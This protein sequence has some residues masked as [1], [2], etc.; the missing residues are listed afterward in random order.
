MLINANEYYL[1]L[2]TKENNIL[3]IRNFNITNWL[4][5]ILLGVI[6]DYK[7]KLNTRIEEIC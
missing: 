7:R 6:F 1:L 4:S 3:K 2:N 5:E